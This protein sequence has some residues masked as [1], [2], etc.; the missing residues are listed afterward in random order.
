MSNRRPRRSR[1]SN[2]RS[3]PLIACD[4]RNATLHLP[5]WTTH[6]RTFIRLV[7]CWPILRLLKLATSHLKKPELLCSNAQR[8]TCHCRATR[9][10]ASTSTLS[11]AKMYTRISFSVLPSADRRSL[12]SLLQATYSCRLRD[13]KPEQLAPILRDLNSSQRRATTALC[14]SRNRAVQNSMVQ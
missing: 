14:P 3:G 13:C 11:V 1:S 6:A 10:E 5:E 9:P 4:V 7:Q 2:S 12:S 8:R